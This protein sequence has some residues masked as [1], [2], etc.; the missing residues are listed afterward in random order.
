MCQFQYCHIVKFTTKL[1]SVKVR[2][3]ANSRR[4]FGANISELLL[5]MTE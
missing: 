3:L 4:D 2:D 1:T 5:V